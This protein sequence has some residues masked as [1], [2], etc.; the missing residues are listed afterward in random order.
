VE[1]S[2]QAMQRCSEAYSKILAALSSIEWKEA[3]TVTPI[4]P[5]EGAA[6]N[7]FPGQRGFSGETFPV[8]GIMLVGNNFDCLKGWETYR[9]V[10]EHES[11]S[12]TWSR[13]RKY[14]VAESG[15]GLERFWF[16]NYCFGVKDNRSKKESSKGDPCYGF[17]ARERRAL[18]FP[19]ASESCVNAMRPVIGCHIATHQRFTLETAPTPGGIFAAG[20]TASQDDGEPHVHLGV[21]W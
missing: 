7:F 20:P 8:G 16:T 18:D 6:P 2:Q 15:L 10:A 3:P 9:T 11:N 13:L 4:A 21:H 19:R 1:P 12:R 17:Y 5:I 14:I